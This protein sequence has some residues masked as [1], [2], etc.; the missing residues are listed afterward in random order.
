MPNR[1]F[2]RQLAR[3]ASVHRSGRNRATHFVGIPLI[4]FSLQLLFALWR[5]E[6]GGHDVSMAIVLGIVAVLGWVALDPGIG[7]IMAALMVPA[8]TA[9]EILAGALGPSSTVTAF[10]VLFIGGWALQ[11]LG[12]RYEGKRPAMADNIFQGFIGPMFLIAE[13]L[14]ASGYR[15]DLAAT[16]GEADVTAR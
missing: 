12:H 14:V 11:F 6:F 10:A 1:L 8:L 3:Y 13:T 7:S 9:A 2:H 15:A 16:M 5:V 4:V